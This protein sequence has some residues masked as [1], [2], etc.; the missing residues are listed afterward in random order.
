MALELTT[1]AKILTN[2][3]SIEPN[4][5]LDIKGFDI[6]F[7]AV[8]VTK[9]AT[10]GEFIIGDGT[11]IGGV[12]PDP[13]SRDYLQ[14]R[15][16]TNNITQKI[17]QD[18]GGANSIT[19]F[20]I[21]LIDKNGELTNLL[22]PG[23]KIVDPLGNEATVYW[24]AQEGKHPQ[25]SVKIFIGIIDRVRF[26]SGFVEVNISNPNQKLRQDVLPKVNTTLSAS[27]DAVQ[28]S[29]TLDSVAGLLLDQDLLSTYIKID[30]E[31]IK[32]GT[33]TGNTLNNCVRAQLN[34]VA[35]THSAQADVS[36]FYRLQGKPV[37]MGLKMM[38]S[39]ASPIIDTVGRVNQ[40]EP[41]LF[42]QNA[43][44]FT[45]FNIQE[46][47]GLVVGDLISISGSIIPTNNFT[48]RQIISF[49]KTT[50]G[51]YL[52]VNGSDLSTETDVA[53]TASIRSK[54]NTLNFGAEMQP[55]QVDVKQFEDM[56]LL[57]NSQFSDY[58]FFID[59]DSIQLKQFLD[60]QV[61]FPSGLF[62]IPRKGRVSCN[63]SAPPIADANTKTLDASN[64]KKASSL[65]IERTINQLFYNAIIY[66]FDRDSLENKFL[67]S[68][69]NV[70]EDS[71]NRIKI[72][73]RPMSIE[74]QGLRDNPVTQNL[75]QVQSRRYL[76]RYQ[77]GAE[78]IE[79]MTKF[80]VGFP[81]ELS[82]TVIFDG[83]NLKVS[84]TTQGTRD[85]SPRIME[86]VNKSI[87]LKTG[88][89]KLTLLDT[90]YSTRARYGTIAPSSVTTSGSTT[91]EIKLTKSFGTSDLS[92]ETEKW[93]QYIGQKIQ[94]R[95]EDYTT[96]I[97]E[98]FI[99]EIPSG[100]VNTL[101]VDPP[102]LSAVPLGFIIEPP[103]YDETS[104]REMRFWKS[105]H[106]FFNPQI[107]VVSGT[108][109]SFDVAV[110]DEARFY[111]DAP[112]LVHSP[113]YTNSFETIVIDVTGQTIAVKDDLG[114]IPALNDEIDLI[115]FKGDKGLPYRVF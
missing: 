58:D 52:V 93:E 88:E 11:K 102:L 77:Y 114:F 62:S 34:T 25:D 87:N 69:I 50:S 104:A 111:I 41:T 32:V 26:G 40:V 49:G 108:N 10:I 1:T 84:D 72:G 54:Y 45:D 31:I 95:S 28:T 63:L 48:D 83:S 80:S 44:F 38:L 78:K 18:K 89:V 22:T 46:K 4:I 59:D 70:S 67:K 66:K 115:G 98:T 12:S 64:V 92:T 6:I 14:L 33:I 109:T 17:N 23:K 82:D 27:I 2:E 35:N 103:N 43:L 74:A 57:F 8:K 68:R 13:K 20:K 107:K 106:S 47:L 5:I 3:T 60:E 39:G 112:V 85:F 7:G 29:I 36:S 91:T 110:G 101:I 81:I 99:K 86:V 21:N 79:V 90:N 15:G 94:V 19:S 9:A 30:N 24:A 71:N 97:G 105:V 75:I 55:Y 96:I 53:L 73:N 37:E 61:F 65:V 16:T 42:I 113:D 56:D 51:S 76:D 100:K